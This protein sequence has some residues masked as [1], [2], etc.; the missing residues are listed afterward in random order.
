MTHEQ[1]DSTS[2]NCGALRRVVVCHQGP[3]LG[4]PQAGVQRHACLQPMIILLYGGEARQVLWAGWQEYIACM[5]WG[6]ILLRYIPQVLHMR[7]HMLLHVCSA[8]PD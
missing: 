1:R 4:R 3:S 5:Y 2:Q 8:C 7:T 6:T